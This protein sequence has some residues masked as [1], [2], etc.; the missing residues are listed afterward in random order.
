MKIAVAIDIP[1]SEPSFFEISARQPIGQASRVQS[2][3]LAL[4]VIPEQ[5]PFALCASI[6]CSLDHGDHS[7]GIG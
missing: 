7:R 5:D 6:V 4:E 1:A 3:R 2:D